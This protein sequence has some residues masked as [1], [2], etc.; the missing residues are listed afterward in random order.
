MLIYFLA[1]RVG[2]GIS[3]LEYYDIIGE[4]RINRSPM[5]VPYL[6]KNWRKHH[7]KKGPRRALISLSV[8]LVFLVYLKKYA[9]KEEK[10]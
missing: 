6:A 8:N 3:I 9:S 2:A 4:N 1:F 5:V 10:C 7:E